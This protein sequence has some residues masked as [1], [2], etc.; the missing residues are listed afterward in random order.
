MNI[1]IGQAATGDK[2]YIREKLINKLWKRIKV[3]NNILVAAPRRLGKTSIM[4]YCQEN[5]QENHEVI[6]IITESVNNQNEFYRKLVK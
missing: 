2:F 5:P 3:G 6:Y 1:I 4:L